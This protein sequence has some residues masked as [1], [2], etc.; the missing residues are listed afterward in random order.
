MGYSSSIVK[1]PV[2]I[3]R[4]CEL[5]RD[6]LVCIVY[7]K[8]NDA[9]S[10]STRCIEK[11]TFFESSLGKLINRITPFYSQPSPIAFLLLPLPLQRAIPIIFAGYE[12]N[13]LYEV[14]GRVLK[15]PCVNIEY[16]HQLGFGFCAKEMSLHGG[17]AGKGLIR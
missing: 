6:L 11:E 12:P 1:I 13:A 14:T 15:Y 2:P 16:D 4:L 17:T 3:A 9:I 10:V 5:S 8:A 7:V